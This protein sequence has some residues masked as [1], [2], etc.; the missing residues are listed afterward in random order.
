MNIVDDILNDTT[1]YRKIFDD[2]NNALKNHDQKNAERNQVILDVYYK[3]YNE[4]N[5]KLQS[6]LKLNKT[7]DIDKTQRAIGKLVSQNPIYNTVNPLYYSTEDQKKKQMVIAK[8]DKLL[9]IYPDYEALYSYL[10]S[11]EG[12]IELSQNP[13]KLNEII[14]KINLFLLNY[15]L[16]EKPDK[17]KDTPIFDLSL[18]EVYKNTIQTAIDIIDDITNLISR[19]EDLTMAEYRRSIFKTITQENR[20]LYV[21]I[22]L[23]FLSFII[24]FIDTSL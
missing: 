6:D 15:P 22:W 8:L 1:D 13:E 23:I 24:Y 5:R 7:D 18:K 14:D 4:V 11:D 16:T 17:F 9:K 2:Y 20:R 3:K 10:V 19:R 21:G 12:S